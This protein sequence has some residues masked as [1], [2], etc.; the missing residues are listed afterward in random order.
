M[1][2][3]T[4]ASGVRRQALG[5]RFFAPLFSFL[6]ISL[7]TFA[8]DDLFITVSSS[9]TGNLFT[10]VSAPASQPVE[11]VKST[12][13]PVAAPAVKQAEVTAKPA[14]EAVTVKGSSEKW[15]QELL[16]DP[17]WPVGFYPDGWQKRAQIR[18]SAGGDASG[19]KA[20]STRLNISGVSRLNG[21]AAAIIN[22]ELKSSGDKVDVFYEG[23]TY[24]WQV[25]E[26]NGQLQL[27]RLGIN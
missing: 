24:Q 17:F 15:E 10:T 13:K 5:L 23:R 11:P 4:R 27:K 26:T 7:V 18:D 20:A 14:A 2:S 9:A 12:L 22:G 16:R 8:Q 21:R 3:W 19:W 25:I 1:S 6:T